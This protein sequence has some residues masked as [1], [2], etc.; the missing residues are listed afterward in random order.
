ML[1]PTSLGNTHPQTLLQCPDGARIMQLNIWSIVPNYHCSVNTMVV[2]ISLFLFSFVI[3]LACG[4]RFRSKTTIKDDDNNSRNNRTP[5]TYAASVQ[6]LLLQHHG[7]TR[8]AWIDNT[9]VLTRTTRRCSCEVGARAA[10]LDQ[11]LLIISPVT[12]CAATWPL[13]LEL[14]L[15]MSPATGMCTARS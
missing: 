7:T 1:S 14:K 8:S 11:S 5:K 13:E 6:S 12:Q 3:W 15:H 10:P 4:T 9:F 2:S